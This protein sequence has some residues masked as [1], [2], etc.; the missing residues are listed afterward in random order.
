MSVSEPLPAA[1]PPR[2]S[3]KTIV[4]AVVVVVLTFL[5]GAAAGFL[6]AHLMY[7]PFSHRPPRMVPQMMV[8]HL[9]RAL[10]L[11]PEQRAKVEEIVKRRHQ[12]IW[13]VT[14]S[15]RPRV[16]QELEEANREIEAILTPEQRVKFEKLK[17]HL[18]HREGRVRRGSTR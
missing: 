6:T 16:H 15:V 17:M 3:K 4:I 12:R 1:P 8:R 10:D 9:S 18:G 14:E 2:G 5:S 11:T 7:R 13:S